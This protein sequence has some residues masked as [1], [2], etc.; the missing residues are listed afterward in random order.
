MSRLAG[1]PTVVAGDNE[2]TS[3]VHKLGLFQCR[4]LAAPATGRTLE[5]QEQHEPLWALQ[6]QAPTD[7]SFSLEGRGEGMAA[8]LNSPAPFLL[9]C[10]TSSNLSSVDSI[11]TLSA[12]LSVRLLTLS[13]QLTLPMS[14]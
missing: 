1:F 3:K 10:S 9:L 8:E 12:L 11:S 2:L 13:A 14:Q 6:Q 4:R 5:A 7:H